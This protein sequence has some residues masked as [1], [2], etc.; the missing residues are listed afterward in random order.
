MSNISNKKISPNKK[1]YAESN[2]AL[3]NVV[4]C[5]NQTERYTIALNNYQLRKPNIFRWSADSKAIGMLIAR[6]LPYDDGGLKLSR[7]HYWVGIWYPFKNK[8]YTVH[9]SNEA[10]LHLNGDL[11]DSIEVLADENLVICSAKGKE[12]KRV[13]MP[14][15][16]TLSKWQK[17][18]QN[19][20]IAKN[21]LANLNKKEWTWNHNADSYEGVHLYEGQVLWF[22]H[23]HNPHSGGG[24]NGQSFEDFLQNGPSCGMPD[25]LFKELYEVVKNLASANVK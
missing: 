15:E 19:L 24:A 11:V 1:F 10:E 20:E 23:C 2:G 7:N 13:E 18:Q 9:F 21:K 8:F 12:F 3:L 14:L 22:Q 16:E 17:E 4:S 6:S 25:E 5:E